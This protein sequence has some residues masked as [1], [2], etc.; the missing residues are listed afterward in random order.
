MR[1]A[2]LATTALAASFT[3]VAAPAFAAEPVGYA[4]TWTSTTLYQLEP[5][6]DAV[7]IADTTGV[8]SVTGL[9]FD[10]DGNGYA[11]TYN[12]QPHLWA[13]DVT[14]DATLVG[15]ITDAGGE[16]ADDCTALDYTD[17][18][19]SVACD[20]LGTQTNVFGIVDPATAII[21]PLQELPGRVS[22]LAHNPVDDTM[23]GFDYDGPVYAITVGTA[24]NVGSTPDDTT[25]W[26][27]DF[28]STGALWVAVNDTTI[29]GTTLLGWDLVAIDAD[30]PDTG[31][32]IENLAV[33]EAVEA[34]V[35]EEEEPAAAPQ[36]ADT[37]FAEGPSTLVALGGGL[38]LL[39]G[40]GLA[41]VARRA[42]RQQ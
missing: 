17:G 3:L 9:D 18:V 39:T 37:G 34:P 4:L 11:V 27:A 12:G 25:F 38:A 1:R 22:S 29:D 7:E 2:A 40:L 42:A 5:G 35:E 32:F 21:T 8:E 13:I 23:Y 6:T 33:Y 19:I 41:L 28:D 36:L 14:G 31:E 15:I 30:I 26:G 16:V 24:T 20:D 10:A